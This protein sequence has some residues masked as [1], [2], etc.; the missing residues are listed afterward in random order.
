MEI[1]NQ[2]KLLGVLF[3]D[4]MSWKA[5]CEAVRGILRSA[6]FLFV[7]MRERVSQSMLRQVYFANVQSHILYSLLIWGGSPHLKE[8]CCAHKRVVWLWQGA[9]RQSNLVDHFTKNMIFFLFFLST[10]LNAQSL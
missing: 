1:A 2:S 3:S 9:G 4:T 5:Q 8:V 6:T 10:Y 7:K